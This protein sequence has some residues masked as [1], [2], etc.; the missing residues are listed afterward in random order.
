MQVTDFVRLQLGYPIPYPSVRIGYGSRSDIHHTARLEGIVVEVK[1][2]FR[3][4]V[5]RV[6]DVNKSFLTG[7]AVIGVVEVHIDGVVHALLPG[8]LLGRSLQNDCKT[9]YQKSEFTHR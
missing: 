5:R 9:D 7:I 6:V 1:E 4:G 2:H 3:D 8:G